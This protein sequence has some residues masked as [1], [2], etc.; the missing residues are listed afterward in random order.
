M[1]V[2][3]MIVHHAPSPAL[4]AERALEK[5]RALSKLAL[6]D[7][8]G[9]IP[10]RIHT[11]HRSCDLSRRTYDNITKLIDAQ[12]EDAGSVEGTLE[13][14]SAHNGYEFRVYEPVWSRAI[15]CS[16]SEELLQ[17]VGN[18]RRAGLDWVVAEVPVD[19]VCKT[20]GT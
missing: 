7:A 11:R 5:A 6:P 1:R 8:D 17:S 18:A 14:V 20:L 10:V 15:R 13:V 3:W 19:V 2:N 12:Y 4:L 9:D 16:F